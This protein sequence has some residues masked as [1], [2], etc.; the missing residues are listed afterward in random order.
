MSIRL[1]LFLAEIIAIFHNYFNAV[2]ADHSVVK[3]L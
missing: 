1:N 2:T 3:L